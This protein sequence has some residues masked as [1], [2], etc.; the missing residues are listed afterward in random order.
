M[1]KIITKVADIAGADTADLVSTYNALTGKSVKKFEN[2]T[3]AERR[4]EMAI[5]AAKDADG[6]T[7]VPKGQEPQAKPR[8]EIVSKA[9]EKGQQPPPALDEEEPTFTPGTM[10][11]ELNKAAKAAKHIEARPKRKK[12]DAEPKKVLYAVVA[13]FAGTSKPQAGSTRNSVL[14]HIQNAPRSAC[15]I[16]DLDK[17]FDGNTR[18]YV[19]KLL[20]KD[21]LQLVNEEQYA[22]LPEVHPNKPKAAA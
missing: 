1:A 11:Y 15:T 22:A 21:H 16:E 10:A 18:G 14:L 20:E 19:Q 12:K 7:G 13:T 5:L 2:R 17:H 8:A 3:V 6:K 4:V 9:E